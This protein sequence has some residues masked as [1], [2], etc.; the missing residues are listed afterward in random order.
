MGVLAVDLGKVEQSLPFF[1]KAVEANSKIE[2]FW[3]SYV[4][5]LINLNRKD[6]ARLA[7]DHAMSVPE[8]N[9]R[10]DKL[11]AL[12]QEVSGPNSVAVQN[13][14]PSENQLREI[15]DLYKSG[16]LLKVISE[17]QKLLKLYPETLTL[18]NILGASAAQTKQLDLAISSFKNVVRIKPDFAD[19]Y[20]NLGNIF[21]NQKNFEEAISAYEKALEIKPDAD[22]YCNI[23]I[24]Y[25]ALEKTNE[26]ISAYSRA[27]EIMPNS[28]PARFNLANALNDLGRLEEALLNY[29]QLH[30]Q[31][32]VAKAMECVYSLQNYSEFNLRLSNLVKQ[33]PFNIRVAALSAFAADQLGQINIYPFCKEPLKM[34]SI[35]NLKNIIPNYDQFIEKLIE[36]IDAHGAAWE[37]HGKTTKGG[38]QSSNHLFSKPLPKTKELE[39]LLKHHLDEY[40]AGFRDHSDEVIQQWPN[41]LELSAWFVKL[42]QGGHQDSHIHPSG[43]ISGVF[44][45]KTVKSPIDNEGAIKFGL[46]GYEYPIKNQNYPTRIYQPSDG[47]LILFPSCLFHETIPVRQDVERCVIAFDLRPN[48]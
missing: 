18:W 24:A 6:D 15:L 43:W 16:D 37:P 1:K 27:L 23:G 32:A 8:N 22:V 14:K 38:F 36:E 48:V 35:T 19:A 40:Y 39:T 33:D 45:I 13:L 29:D 10:F 7:V 21:V 9:K 41:K 12:F 4:S 5:A 34:V 26:A 17:A 28:A 44:Y 25:K 2:Q 3:L 42:I 20:S 47:D 46:H 11:L 30:T 31:S